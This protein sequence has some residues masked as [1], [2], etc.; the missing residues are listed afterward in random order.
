M[1]LADTTFLIDCL[2][3][4]QG[5]LALLAQFSGEI[6]YTTEINAFECYLGLYANKRV[7]GTPSLMSQRRRMLEELLARFHIL[8]FQRRETIEAAAILGQLFREGQP[9]EFRDAL[10]AGIARANGVTQILTRNPMHFE[11]IEGIQVH[12]YELG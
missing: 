12:P 11:R 1:I 3:K 7:Y 2:R 6:L 9:I 5:V 4:K 8:P 10:I